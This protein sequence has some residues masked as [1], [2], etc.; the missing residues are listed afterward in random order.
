VENEGKALD[1]VFRAIDKA[2]K[3]LQNRTKTRKAA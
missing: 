1:A 3:E 2:A